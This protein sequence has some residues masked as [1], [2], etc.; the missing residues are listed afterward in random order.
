MIEGEERE[1]F[2]RSLE[3]ATADHTGAALDAVLRELGWREALAHDLR[4]AVA[5][6]FARQGAANA[7]SGALDQVLTNALGDTA[8]ANAVVLP[9]IGRCCPPGSLVDS[10]LRVR[11]IGTASIQPSGT[12]LV[13]A[14]SGHSDLAF[15]VE[16][17]SLPRHAIDGVDPTLGLTRIEGEVAGA[18][19][20]G[21]VDWRAAVAIGQLALG[22]ELV[23]ASRRMLELACEHSLE[24]VQ[25][26]RP[27]AKFQAIRHRLADTLVA[28]EA[29]DALLEAAWLD[30][31]AQSAAMAKATAARSA[32]AAARH[33]QQVLAG[34]GFTTEHPLHRYIRRILVLEQFL[35]ST[36]TLTTELGN[37]IL[38]HGQLPSLL[39]L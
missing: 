19:E 9:P 27:I 20:I 36:R 2:D 10:R 17:G 6:L 12:A 21:A 5:L 22:H 38:E 24:R 34:T 29:A 39:P 1:L 25:F 31:V 13:V 28:I 18:T 33:C 37:D 23:G 16:T 3:R 4:A 35:G 14:R 11:G 32:R 15:V 8:V 7:T 26:D 30:G